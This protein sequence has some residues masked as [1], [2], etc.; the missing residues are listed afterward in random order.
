LL[1]QELEVL[2]KS[3]ESPIMVYTPMWGQSQ[4]NFTYKLERSGTN[5]M[6]LIL[7]AKDERHLMG[8]VQ[9]SLEEE[10]PFLR[11]MHPLHT[12]KNNCTLSLWLSIRCKLL[13]VT[14][15]YFRPKT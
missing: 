7:F 3:K 15:V 5:L 14:K 11:V 13:W 6:S 1:E 8:K 9:T 12:I 4:N 10:I 2:D